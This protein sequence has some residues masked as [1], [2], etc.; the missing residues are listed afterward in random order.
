MKI[1]LS[2]SALNILSK[3]NSALFPEN[4][5]T[6]FPETFFKAPNNLICDPSFSEN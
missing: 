1:A 3:L 6:I 2:W 4:L 5:S